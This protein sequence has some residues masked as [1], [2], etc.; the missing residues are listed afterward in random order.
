MRGAF[1]LIVT[2]LLYEL[3]DGVSKVL[4]LIKL[5]RRLLRRPS[6]GRNML[7]GQLTAL[8]GSSTQTTS[9]R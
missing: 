3:A 7:P 8:A 5:R 2:F 4:A 1:K 6:C 9:I